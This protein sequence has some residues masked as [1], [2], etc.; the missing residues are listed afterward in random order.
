MARSP[1]RSSIS[2]R[3]SLPWHAPAPPWPKAAWLIGVGI[4]GVAAAAGTVGALVL[5]SPM[6]GLGAALIAGGSLTALYAAVT[7]TKRVPR[8]LLVGLVLAMFAAGWLAPRA[9]WP[10]EAHVPDAAVMTIRTVADERVIDLRTEDLTGIDEVR[11]E[12][13]ASDV[14]VLLPGPP[15]SVTSNVLLS[16]VSVDTG[17]STAAPLAFDVTVDATLSA[18]TLEERS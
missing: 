16:D 10:S 3:P 1:C 2:I 17:T 14:T 6:L 4:L 11:I 9:A 5:G 13:I 7:R 12:A 8:P 15:L 18:V